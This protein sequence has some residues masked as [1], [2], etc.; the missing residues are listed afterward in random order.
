VE[1]DST[2]VDILIH[3]EMVDTNPLQ[4]GMVDSFEFHKE[5]D[6]DNSNRMVSSVQYH[7]FSVEVDS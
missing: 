5:M 6:N 4:Q 3:G 2:M 7:S 1:P